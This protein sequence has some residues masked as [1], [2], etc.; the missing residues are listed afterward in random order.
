MSPRA[1]VAAPDASEDAFRG[2]TWDLLTI[3]LVLVAAK[4]GGVA[5]QRFGLP[6]VF[7]KLVVGLALGPAILNLLEPS[8]S[9][10][11]LGHRHRLADVHR[12]P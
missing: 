12:R 6:A 9:L 5:S 2:P 8:E 7:G 10:N 11:S 1:S 3:A 4:L